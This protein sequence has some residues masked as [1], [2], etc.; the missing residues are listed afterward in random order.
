MDLWLDCCLQSFKKISGACNDQFRRGLGQEDNIS[1]QNLQLFN[2]I[3]AL[4]HVPHD[5]V[6]MLIKTFVASIMIQNIH[7]EHDDG[8]RVWGNRKS[9][10]LKT[11]NSSTTF[12]H[13]ITF[14]MIV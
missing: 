13:C 9:F 10:Q 1:T 4:Y 6:L 12:A 11:F 14:R 7:S 8:F 5:C 3:R 2:Y